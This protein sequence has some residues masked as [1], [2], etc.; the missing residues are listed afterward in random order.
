MEGTGCKHPKS[1]EV[2]AGFEETGPDRGVRAGKSRL[3]IV[4]RHRL[5][6][7]KFGEITSPYISHAMHAS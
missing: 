6:S 1:D 4:I 5:K 3:W 2:S 7:M